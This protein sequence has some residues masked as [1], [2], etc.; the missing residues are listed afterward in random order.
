MKT[1]HNTCKAFVANSQVRK[2]GLHGFLKL[3]NL[4]FNNLVHWMAYHRRATIRVRARR[5]PTVQV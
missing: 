5:T 4:T 3:A 1:A 2:E